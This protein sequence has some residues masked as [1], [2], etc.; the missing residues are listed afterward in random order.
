MKNLYN[1]II[2]IIFAI[3]FG[4]CVITH[5]KYNILEQEYNELLFEKTSI[6]DSLEYDNT[7]KS[8]FISELEQTILSLN[9]NLDSLYN[10]KMNI[11]KSENKFT[12]SSSISHGAELLKQNLNEKD[13]TYNF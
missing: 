4:Q 11:Q 10:I 3:V 5:K 6:I 1:W 8:E 12:I 13:F 2:I 7:K 9:D